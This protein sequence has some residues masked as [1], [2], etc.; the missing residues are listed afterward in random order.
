MPG[1]RFEMI[2]SKTPTVPE[3]SPLEEEHEDL[4]VMFTVHFKIGVAC[5]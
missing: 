4:P 5:R 3:V 2:F 1:S